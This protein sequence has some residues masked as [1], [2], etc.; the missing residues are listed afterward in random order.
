MPRQLDRATPYQRDDDDTTNQPH[1][2]ARCMRPDVCHEV[3]DADASAYLVV[4]D[5]VRHRSNDAKQDDADRLH[6]AFSKSRQ[7]AKLS[8][9]NPR[10]T[11]PGTGK[12]H[13]ANATSRP[14]HVGRP[15]PSWQRISSPA[16]AARKTV[17]PGK[18]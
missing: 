9:A 17:T 4:G 12:K 7:S 18:T 8:A 1:K 3:L 6:L 10:K 13:G 14:I 15:A 11:S 16:A 5:A 2:I